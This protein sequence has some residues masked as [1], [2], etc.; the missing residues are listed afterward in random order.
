M[1]PAANPCGLTWI[2][3]LGKVL[4]EPKTLDFQNPGFS[5]CETKILKYFA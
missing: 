4:K 3:K 2:K 1:P 5:G